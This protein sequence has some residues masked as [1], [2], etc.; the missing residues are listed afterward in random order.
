MPWLI[1]LSSF[2]APRRRQKMAEL[3]VVYQHAPKAHNSERP[4]ISRADFTWCMTA[5]YWGWSVEDT[6]ARLIVESR[7][8][9]ENGETYA[10][11]TARNAA[12]AIHSARRPKLMP[13]SPSAPGTPA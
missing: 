1:H 12:S 9:H 8:A 2:P 4:D 5:I 3:P 6:A 7:K 13:L 10:I 11:T